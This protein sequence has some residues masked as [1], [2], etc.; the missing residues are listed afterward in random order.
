[1]ASRVAVALGSNLGDRED[2]LQTALRRLRAEPGLR[3]VACSPIYETTPID[4]PPDSANFLNAVALIE[5][6]LP[7]HEVLCRLLAIERRLGRVRDQRH[8]PRTIDLDLLF[9]DQLIL[10]T[11]ELTL[12]HP[13]LAERPFV[14]IPLADIA[15][16]WFHP[17]LQCTVS[18]LVAGLSADARATVRPYQLVRSQGH[19]RLRGQR[20]L[21]T[22]STRGIGA[23]IAAAFE[24]EGATVLRHGR[25]PV[26]DGNGVFGADLSDPAAVN[27]LAASAWGSEGLDILVCNAGVDVLTGSAAHWP[28]EQKLEAL[29]AVDVRATIVLARLIGQRMKERGHG[30]ILTIGWDQAETGMEGDSGQLFAA[31]KAAVM[32]FTRSLAR[33]LAPEVR[34]NCIAPGWIRTAWGEMASQYWQERVRRETLLAR[35]GLPEDVAAAAIWLA[36]PEASYVTGQTIHINGGML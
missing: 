18:E 33:S 7:P 32:A 26:G 27:T 24:R 30:C 11:P 36:S 2:Y 31:T 8:A 3:L 29:W 1:M 10:S 6:E 28:F 15:G 22:G 9:Y 14:L 16:D 13:R 4:C 5:T 12:P 20:A 19:G 35:W 23:A 17:Q 34:V 21:V 25:H